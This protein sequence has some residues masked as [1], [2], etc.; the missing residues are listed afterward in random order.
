MM[1]EIKE[2]FPKVTASRED[3]DIHL[4]NYSTEGGE[5]VLKDKLDLIAKYGLEAD[6]LDFSIE[7][8]A[9]GELEEKLKAFLADKS[10]LALDT[11]GAK[12]DEKFV[13][14]S[15]IR[16]ELCRAIETETIQRE[17]GECRRYW[18]VDYDKDARMI[19]CW[20]VGD[21]LLYG[22]AYEM[23]GDAV[24]INYESKKRMKYEIVDF[25]NGEQASPFAGMFAVLEGKIQS[26]TG[27]KAKY[28]EASDA[29]ASMETELDAL[30][31]FKA[32]TEA[33]IAKGEKDEVFARFEDLAGAEAF[34]TLKAEAEKYDA[35]TLEEKC[36]AIRGR[37]S[38][39]KFS[40]EREKAPKLKVEKHD[41]SKEPY[42]DLFHKYGVEP[43]E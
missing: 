41:T 19:Y 23:N 3:D 15:N 2:C 26:D 28:Q 20:D 39:I 7:D 34:E 30:R 11:G 33:A 10:S 1:L 17:W 16:E 22:F 36:F 27:L 42:G 31:Q 35:A 14:E 43:K 9:V 38:A 37:N 18:F 12:P 5:K 13:L 29:I 4:Q 8:I 32:N 6:S 25:D 24:V 21:W 40:Y